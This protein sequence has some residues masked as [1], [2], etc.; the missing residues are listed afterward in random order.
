M[1]TLPSEFG[2]DGNSVYAFFPLMTP[3]AMKV[4]LR[5]MDLEDKYDFA[6]PQKK[7]VG[8]AVVADRTRKRAENVLELHGKGLVLFLF[9]AFL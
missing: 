8:P 7:K 4:H 3:G 5:E 2:E 1:R 6:R 9:D